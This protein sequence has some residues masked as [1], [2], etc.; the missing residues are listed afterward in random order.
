MRS[1]RA[2]SLS[3]AQSGWAAAPSCCKCEL[4]APRSSRTVP[5]LSRWSTPRTRAPFSAALMMAGTPA[6]PTPTTT[7]S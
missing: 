3:I 2:S 4:I 6:V 1:S 7:T 5:T